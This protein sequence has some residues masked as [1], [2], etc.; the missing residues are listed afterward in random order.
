MTESGLHEVDR[1]PP[2]QSMGRVSMAQPMRGNR[3][4]YA[5]AVSGSLDDAMNL[6][7]VKVSLSLAAS[8]YRIIPL[9]V[10]P[11][12]NQFLPSLGG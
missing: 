4:S 9:N 10:I 6:S 12:G 8:D 5:G 11:K 3:I 2:I 7:G 1:S